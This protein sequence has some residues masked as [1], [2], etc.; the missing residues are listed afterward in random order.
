MGDQGDWGTYGGGVRKVM[1]EL[2]GHPPL[3]LTLEE[4]GTS[5]HKLN[6]EVFEYTSFYP[7][8]RQCIGLYCWDELL[9]QHTQPQLV[10]EIVNW[11]RISANFQPVDPTFNILYAPSL[12]HLDMIR[13]L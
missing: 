13:C 8:Y 1:C 11:I 7:V 6:G 9:S 12:L 3:G 5:R 2:I 4:E 10:P